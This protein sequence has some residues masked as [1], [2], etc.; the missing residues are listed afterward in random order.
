MN[1]RSLVSTED[2][3]KYWSEKDERGVARG[4]SRNL[5][6]QVNFATVAAIRAI[7]NANRV[8]WWDECQRLF[9]C[10]PSELNY[11]AALTFL[12]WIK[13]EDRRAVEPS[14]LQEVSAYV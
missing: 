10:E 7:G 1:R 14:P 2:W 8:D 13:K 12:N 4:L 9:S 6:E 5:T 11:K 3:L